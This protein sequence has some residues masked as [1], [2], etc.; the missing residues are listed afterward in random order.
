MISSDKGQFTFGKS[1]STYNLAEF[2]FDYI[3]D[4]NVNNFISMGMSGS[5]NRFTVAS[6]GR[7]AVGYT[8]PQNEMFE[9]GGNI[10]LSGRIL[11]GS[12]ADDTTTGIQGE[13]LRIEGAGAIGGNLLIGGANNFAEVD[14]K[15]SID[16][17]RLWHFGVSAGGDFDFVESLIS[18]RFKIE[19]GGAMFFTGTPTFSGLSTFNDRIIQG[20]VT[21]DNTT[22]IIGESLKIE[23][24]GDFEDIVTIKA[25]DLGTQE[26]FVLE[27]FNTSSTGGIK[28]VTKGEGFHGW[29]VLRDDGSRR[30]VFQS[31][32]DG[33]I[34]QFELKLY[35]TNGSNEQIAFRTRY[36]EYFETDLLLKANDR[37]IQGSATDD[38][39]TGI[40][41]ESLKIE[42]AGN[43][44]DSVTAKNLLSL[45]DSY[46]YGNF[47]GNQNITL[48]ESTAGSVNSNLYHS[49][50]MRVQGNGAG[51]AAWQLI[52]N[53]RD[54]TSQS[55][56]EEL[57]LSFDSTTAQ[58]QGSV[59]ADSLTVTQNIGTSDRALN[60]LIL[61]GGANSSAPVII[62]DT[63]STNTSYLS[64]RNGVNVG[65]IL[66][67]DKEIVVYGSIQ[68][69]SYTTTQKNV[70]SVVE[71]TQIYDSTLKKICFYNGTNWETI[72]SS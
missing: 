59:T 50:D 38:N 69:A 30:V 64:V 40:I 31:R 58:F 37:I 56:I 5:S 54:G 44:G 48:G 70:L 27:Q 41:G 15:R 13:S 49:F 71:G 68:N 43:F 51:S 29:N 57:L 63:D 66:T 12:V 10:A 65:D 3:S 55:S 4:A 23:G 6:D 45:A 11:Q 72:T 47:T 52:A 8:S 2:A 7:S 28:I 26:P 17:S 25:P 18:S 19:Q 16:A 14:M 20:S 53:K 67:V 62:G 42:G 24:T 21:D 33:N 34:G 36:S 9:V 39:T 1:E 60:A 22:G 46:G 35:D 61:Q 32:P